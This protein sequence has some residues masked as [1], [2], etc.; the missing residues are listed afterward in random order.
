[1][2]HMLALQMFFT[3]LVGLLLIM[4]VL[5]AKYLE[6]RCEVDSAVSQI[7]WTP[8]GFALARVQILTSQS[9]ATARVMQAC[10][11]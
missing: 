7:V 3:G 6:W 11:W 9:Y 10:A 5:L 2:E 4:P 1:M 8:Q